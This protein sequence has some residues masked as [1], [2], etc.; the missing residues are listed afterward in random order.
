MEISSPNKFHGK[1]TN[2]TDDVDKEFSKVFT[3][4]IKKIQHQNSQRANSRF[5]NNIFSIIYSCL[6]IIEKTETQSTSPVQTSRHTNVRSKIASFSEFLSATR[7][8]LSSN[9]VS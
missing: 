1:Y 8:N 9:E 3:E 5:T 6:S 2:Q 7:E 4:Y